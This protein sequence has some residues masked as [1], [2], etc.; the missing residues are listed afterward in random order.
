MIHE[1]SRGL[2]H[3]QQLIHNFYSFCRKKHA[4]FY[5]TYPFLQNTYISLTILHIY[6][7]K[8][9]KPSHHQRSIP[10][11][12]SSTH[13]TTIIKLASI[14][15]PPIKIPTTINLINTHLSKPSKPTDQNHQNSFIKII[16]PTNQNHQTNKKDRREIRAIWWANEQST[17]QNHQTTRNLETRSTLWSARDQMV[18]WFDE[19]RKRESEVRVSNQRQGKRRN[20]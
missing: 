6:L 7:I 14:M 4:F 2:E 11:P 18:W 3:L 10:N 5:F 19:M 17:N 8:Y 1:W 16:K 20:Y 9:Y 13:T 12:P 15:N